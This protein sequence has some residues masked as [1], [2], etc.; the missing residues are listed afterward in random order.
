MAERELAEAI[1]RTNRQIDEQQAKLE[2]IETV[3]SGAVKVAGMAG[4]AG[5]A[6]TATLTVPLLAFGRAAFQAA[7]D[8][9]ELESAFNVTF[10][11]QAAAMDAWAGRTGDAI[12]RTKVELMDAANTFGIFFNM[13]DP[14]KS[15]A[16]SQQF[17]LLAQDLSSF[18][19]VDPGTAMDKL[20]S[21]LTGESEPLRDFGV[22]MTEAAVKAAA[23]K[24]GLKPVGKEFT[25]QQK[26][27][28]R[29]ALIM[30]STRSAQGDLLRTSDQTANKLRAADAA[31][32]NMTLT[33]GQELIPAL[34]PAISTFTDLIKSF[35]GLSPETRKWIVI[36]GGMLAV[37]GPILLGFSAV[38]GAVATLAPIIIGI[39]SAFGTVASIIGGVAAA[40]GAVPLLI[41]AAVAAVGV[42]AYMIYTHWDQVES[43]LGSGIAWLKGV[44]NA[45]PAWMRNI[46]S[47][48][49]QGLLMSL[50]PALLVGKLIGIAKAGVTAFKNYFG[51][52]SPS[53]LFME[54]GG[55]INDGLGIGLEKG[56]GRPVRAVGRMAG[57]VAG[58]G[59]MALSPAAAAPRAQQ[60]AAPAKI[61]IHV[62]QMPGENSEAL[63][64]RVAELVEQAQRQSARRGYGDDF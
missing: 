47:M 51:I 9:G 35:A 42:A 28:A 44:F 16:M 53:R 13:A 19:N 31:W 57:A 17:A 32:Q 23:L 55:H 3:R 20:R 41:A 27:M 38:A 24:M 2:R 21:G 56:K 29:A 6:A 48:M 8:A 30:E 7:V 54:M 46:G 62:H 18:Y 25:E 4:R 60:S 14:S 59:A 10:G 22:F 50:N 11:K 45:L 1:E 36:G 15:A 34:T 43:A 12:G 26:I 58:A 63:A 39:G 64:Q 37:L 61:E 5:A 49:M 40:I 33:I 52:R